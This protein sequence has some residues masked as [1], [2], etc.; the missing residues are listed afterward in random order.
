[1]EIVERHRAG[2]V[3]SASGFVLERSP[4]TVRGPDV[5]FISASRVPQL[6]AGY[7]DAAPDIAIEVLSP[8]NRPDEMR[9]EVRE[10]FNAGARLVWIV[11]PRSKTVTVYS[12]LERCRVLTLRDELDGGD[13][14][15]QFR[16]SLARLF[17]Y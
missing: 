9:L 11:D 14:L 12:S 4:P 10:Y 13:V 6:P 15:P 7:V 3:V 2:I 16:L 1:M 8:S 5:A 17:T